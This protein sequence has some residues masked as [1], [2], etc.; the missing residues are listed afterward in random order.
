V[1]PCWF[2]LSVNKLRGSR[3]R[4]TRRTT[5]RIQCSLVLLSACFAVSESVAS[6]FARRSALLLHALGLAGGFPLSSERGWSVLGR[7]PTR[8][9]ALASGRSCVG[10]VGPCCSRR[11]RLTR[12]DL[13]LALLLLLLPRGVLDSRS[14]SPADSIE[15]G[16][17]SRGVPL[18]GSVLAPSCFAHQGGCLADPS[19]VPRRPSLDW[20]SGR[21]RVLSDNCDPIKRRMYILP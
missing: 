9:G 20:L 21:D 16:R 3:T 13:L 14:C 1:S 8:F 19:G 12:R 5:R 7:C 18:R 17:R 2:L 15:G 10:V 11:V 6:G 4:S